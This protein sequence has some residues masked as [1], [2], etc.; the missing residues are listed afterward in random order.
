MLN[1]NISILPFSVFQEK[2]IP[3]IL[4]GRDLIAVAQTGTGKTA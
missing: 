4:E 1:I 2:S 3:V